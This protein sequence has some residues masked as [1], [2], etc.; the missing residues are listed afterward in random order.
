[1]YE[2]KDEL[3]HFSEPHLHLESKV[4]RQ[5]VLKKPL[6]LQ[7][8]P[9]LHP[10]LFSLQAP[11]QGSGRISIAYHRIPKDA[12]KLSLLDDLAFSLFNWFPCLRLPQ[13]FA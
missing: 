12:P 13:S 4:I 8:Y 11:P 2:L 9:A 6:Q 10:G 5:M 1:M 3:H 7:F